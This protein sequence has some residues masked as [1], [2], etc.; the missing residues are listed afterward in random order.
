MDGDPSAH[1]PTVTLWEM[2]VSRPSVFCS[3]LLL[4]DHDCP[5]ASYLA[6][7]TCQRTSGL[8]EVALM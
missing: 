4:S 6:A 1:S 7:T 8:Y 3:Q 5:S 2:Y